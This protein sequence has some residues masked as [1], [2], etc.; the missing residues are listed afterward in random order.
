MNV[1]EQYAKIALAEKLLRRRMRLTTVKFLTDLSH[2]MLTEI[3][4]EIAGNA[5]SAGR[6]KS[7][8][9]I[10][11]SDTRR[12]EASIFIKIYLHIGGDPVWTEFD[13]EAFIRSYDVHCESMSRMAAARMAGEYEQEININY[14][15]ALARDIRSNVLRRRKCHRCK[16]PYVYL[17]SEPHTKCPLCATLVELPRTAPARR[18]NAPD[19]HSAPGSS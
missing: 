5:A 17:D 12:S 1:L 2:Y 19:A 9:T 8:S 6:Q 13:I 4:R 11:S 16:I 18:Y 15:W 14:A 3:H 10:L 7:T